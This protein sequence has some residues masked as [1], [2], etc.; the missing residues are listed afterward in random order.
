MTQMRHATISLE[1]NGAD[2][3]LPLNKRTDKFTYNDPESGSS[4]DIS[5]SVIDPDERWIN[6]HFPSLEDKIGA[7]ISVSDWMR[8]GDNRTLDCGMF[9]V[10]DPSFSGPPCKVSFKAVS[11]PAEGCFTATK[12]TQTWENVSVKNMAQEIAG[13]SNLQ[14]QYIADEENNQVPCKEISWKK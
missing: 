8:P 12:R 14:L 13:R 5:L 7:K 2:I 1:Y 10:D 11:K 9:I 6:E 4:D 3:T